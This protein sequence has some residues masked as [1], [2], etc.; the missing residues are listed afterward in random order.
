MRS[1]ATLAALAALTLAIAFPPVSHAQQTTSVDA[2]HRLFL[3]FAEDAAIVPSYWL[4]GQV[5]LELALPAVAE[6][7]DGAGEA[8]LLAVGP[9]FAFN[10]AED[11]EFGARMGV[12]FRDPE[13]GDGD[14]GMTDLDIWGKISVVSDPMAIALGILVKLPTA[15]ESKLMGTGET[16]IEFFAG[17]RKD[18]SS[19]TVAGNL[20]V[21]IN[22]DPEFDEDVV[23]IA[24]KDSVLAGLAIIVPI[25]ARWALTGEWALETERIDGF[26][27]DSRLLGGVEYRPDESF[28]F[29]GSAAA[30]LADGSPDW[31]AT[32]AA[33][34]LF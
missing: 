2:E 7:V 3:R 10:V 22:Q 30:G 26:K 24:G 28:S 32:G 23:E 9:V 14:S 20:G 33:V 5:R 25:G 16:D 17:A 8:D 18:F 13:N 4:E 34:W 19:F 11:F 29:R 21:R 6:S 27:N 15:D 1:R 31:T 12:A